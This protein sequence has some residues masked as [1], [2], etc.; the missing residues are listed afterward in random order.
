MK[1]FQRRKD[2]VRLS[3]EERKLRQR[4]PFDPAKQV[5]VIRS[6]VCTGEKAAGFRD[7]EG[8]HFTEVMLIRSREDE[9]R[10][11]AIYG[12]DSVKVEY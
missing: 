4:I 9:E 5:A 10:F 8:R 7:T 11:K 12:L 3:A 2:P 6:S 1:L